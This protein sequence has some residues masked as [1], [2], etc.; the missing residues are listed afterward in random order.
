M[1]CEILY[2]AGAFDACEIATIGA[3]LRASFLFLTF[4]KYR[5]LTKNLARSFESVLNIFGW[6]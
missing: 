5:S 4:F 2:T 3:V 6:R 1:K